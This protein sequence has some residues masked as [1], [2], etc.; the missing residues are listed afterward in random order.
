[1]S[2]CQ[3]TTL[4]PPEHSLEHKNGKKLRCKQFLSKDTDIS[5]R[6]LEDVKVLIVVVGVC[7]QFRNDSFLVRFV[8]FERAHESWQLHH[9]ALV[10]RL[11]SVLR[12]H[13]FTSTA[14]VKT[15]EH[16]LYDNCKSSNHYLV[17]HM[18]FINCVVIS[19]VFYILQCKYRNL[20]L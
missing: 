2:T 6:L 20:L 16:Y 9:R 4:K 8:Q 12:T 17:D 1:M 15:G 19:H 5:S 10:R 14:L 13:S 3:K 18:C 7:I 11:S